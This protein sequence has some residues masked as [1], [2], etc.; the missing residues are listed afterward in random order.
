MM[1]RVIWHGPAKR[2]CMQYLRSAEASNAADAYLHAPEQVPVEGEQVGQAERVELLLRHEVE[3]RPEALRAASLRGAKAVL[4][5]TAVLQRLL[6]CWH[7][8]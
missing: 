3:A 5:G 7:S 2:A 6:W 4:R 1:E 8:V